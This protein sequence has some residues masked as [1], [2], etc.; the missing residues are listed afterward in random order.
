MW[1]AARKNILSIHNLIHWVLNVPGKWMAQR[2]FPLFTSRLN[3][4][5]TLW[6]MLLFRALIGG[7]TRR[8]R[9]VFVL[10]CCWALT[11]DRPVLAAPTKQRILVVDRRRTPY[12]RASLYVKFV[13]GIG[14]YV[15]SIPCVAIMK[16]IVR[17]V[18]CSSIVRAKCAVIVWTDSCDGLRPME[19]NRFDL[20]K[21]LGGCLIRR[22]QNGRPAISF[23]Y[24]F[25]SR[26]CFSGAFGS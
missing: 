15:F 22:A 7:G 20:G 16:L 14:Q 1:Y 3:V 21:H 25:S 24:V 4:L 18:S 19:G 17:T 8:R 26:Y 11:L 9:E 10:F 12:C 23:R 13:R 2:Y 5:A 6:L